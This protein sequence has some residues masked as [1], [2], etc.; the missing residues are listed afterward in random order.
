M[1]TFNEEDHVNFNDEVLILRSK[2]KK[3]S[4][5][6]NVIPLSS[7]FVFWIVPVEYFQRALFVLSLMNL[8]MM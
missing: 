8:M 7:L 5:Q 1:S 4:L 3:M 2:N 6:I